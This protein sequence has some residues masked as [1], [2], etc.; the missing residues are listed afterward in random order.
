VDHEK[1]ARS[2]EHRLDS[3]WFGQGL[4]I[5]QRALDAALQMVA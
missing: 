5:K 2:N 1:R 3:A 4:A